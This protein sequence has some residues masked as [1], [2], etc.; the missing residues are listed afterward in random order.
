MIGS[1]RPGLRSSTL[2]EPGTRRGPPRLVV[3]V[4]AGDHGAGRSLR[5]PPL[6]RGDGRGITLDHDLYTAVLHVAGPPGHP[7]SLRLLLTGVAITRRLHPAGP[8]RVAGL[9]IADRP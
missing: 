9:T 6:Q 8:R 5:T 7:E 2:S 4:D 1:A 3:S